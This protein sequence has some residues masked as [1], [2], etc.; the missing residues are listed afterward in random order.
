MKIPKLFVSEKDKEE[1]KEIVQKTLVEKILAE[2][3]GKEIKEQLENQEISQRLLVVYE[4]NVE[5]KGYKTREE[6]KGKAKHIYLEIQE[7]V[8]EETN[9]ILQ[10]ILK[11]EKGIKEDEITQTN[12]VFTII[13]KDV[14]SKLHLGNRGDLYEK[15]KDETQPDGQ[16]VVYHCPLLGGTVE[17]LRFNKEHNE[18][19][20]R[21]L[22]NR[23][24][25]V[26]VT[27]REAK[28]EKK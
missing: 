25:N 3:L 21:V 27:F 10:D 14:I 13:T 22:K 9:S 20:I 23:G 17:Y 11:T 12:Y 16:F 18:N 2:D 1:I 15:T 24:Y 6:K 4:K 5:P 26:I 8:K 7:F 19:L 28:S